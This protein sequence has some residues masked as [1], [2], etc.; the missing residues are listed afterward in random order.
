MKSPDAP[1]PQNDPKTGSPAPDASS[2]EPKSDTPSENKSD[3]PSNPVSQEAAPKPQT[4]PAKSGLKKKLGIGAGVLC[5]LLFVGYFVATSAMFVKSAVLPQVSNMIAAQI[6]LNDASISPFSEVSFDGIEVTPNGE[7]MLAS[8]GSVKA[9]YSLMDIVGGNINVDE[10]TVDSPVIQLVVKEDGTTNLDPILKALA[11]DEAPPPGP[12][13]QLDVK[14]VSIKNATIRLIQKLGGGQQQTVE[15]KD[16]NFA[17]DKLGN[18]QSG[19]LNLA[20]VLGLATPTDKLSSKIEGGYDLEIGADLMPTKVSGKT[21]VTIADADGMLATA[22]GLSTEL[23]VDLTPTELKETS[24]RFAQDGKQLGQ[25]TVSGPFDS[26][27]LSADLKVALENIDKNVLNIVGA[28]LGL[29]FGTTTISSQNQI[30]LAPNAEMLTVKGSLAIDKLTLTQIGPGGRGPATPTMD[31][32]VGYDVAVNL[33]GQSATL[34]SLALS[35]STAKGKFLSGDLKAPLTASFAGPVKVTG[36]AGYKLAVTDFDL[37]PWSAFTGP[38]APEG[39]VG[40]TLDVSAD[41]AGENVK[42][43]YGF[44][45][46][47]GQTV[48]LAVNGAVGFSLPTMA[49]DLTSLVDLKLSELRIPGAP[50]IPGEPVALKI[51][52]ALKADLNNASANIARANVAASAGAAKIIDGALN[53]P[54]AVSWKDGVKASGG[55]SYRLNVVDFDL[56]HAK[57]FAG[58]AVPAGVLNFKLNL[59]ADES[60]ANLAVDYD[61]NLAQNGARV[62]GVSGKVAVELAAMAIDLKAALDAELSQLQLADAPLLPAEQDA[63]VKVAVDTQFD[64]KTLKIAKLDSTFLEHDNKVTALGLTGT[65][66]TGDAITI[67]N[68]AV[69]LDPTQRAR[70]KLLISGQI[71]PGD[72][73]AGNIDVKSDGLDVTPFLDLFMPEQTADAPA[74]P[75]ETKPAP[76]QP[77]PGQPAPDA[78]KEP[79]AIQLPIDKFNVDVAIAKLFAREVA[80]SNY[81]TKVAVVGSKVN[82]NPVSLTFNG[83]PLNANANVNLGVPGYEYDLGLKI[84][85]L[86]I[87]PLVDTFVPEY[88]GKIQAE[89]LTDVAIKGKG[90]TGV[91]LKKHLNGHAGT[92]M[93][94][95]VMN[96]LEKGIVMKYVAAILGAPEILEPP[97]DYL[98]ASAKIGQGSV[99]IENFI[100]QSQA[101]QAT[102]AGSITLDD[103]LTNSALNIPVNIKLSKNLAKNVKL[104]DK[105]PSEKYTELPQ[106]V[107][108][109]GTVGAHEVQLD[110]GKLLAV[111]IQA[112]PAAALNI[113]KNAVGTAV[114]ITEKTAD[115]LNKITEGTVGGLLNALGDSSAK[116]TKDGEKK[117]G[118][119]LGGLLGGLG[120]T[121]ATSTN[122]PPK[123][124]TTSTNK[125]PGLKLPFN[126]FKK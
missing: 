125:E 100:A 121:K 81:V 79:D 85:H 88:K 26:S 98:N 83:A 34:N 7:E 110:R 60:G 40:V 72:L 94:N 44:Q 22:K 37:A 17:V 77:A 55:A 67:K 90:V 65:V 52:T 56:R 116:S 29:D 119:V 8:V 84:H 21:T 114:N 48:P 62:A 28:L 108:I 11:T 14:N 99:A 105:A 95:A 35:G 6:K 39:S 23:K 3:G 104:I 68:T 5:G 93:T 61:G 64:G 73:L 25:I 32:G 86:P 75:A 91:N 9:R 50:V 2:S 43:S 58:D 89:L 30:G 41:K 31:L 70:N 33:V 36:N 118:G 4:K 97:L 42:A 126:P 38:G 20:A 47:Q 92:T 82:V 124:A 13:P 54:L 27:K 53:K 101:F 123:D 122:S 45:L 102:A 69:Q 19:K 96:V 111:G 87:A 115:K 71:K 24:V 66:E 117:S 107:T 106:F 15:I 10:V 78:N 46:K 120:G 59:A 74:K 51:D 63:S 80:I 103:V 49:V 112:A 76:E 57:A 109:G 18:G 16:V 12:T 113:G 1:D